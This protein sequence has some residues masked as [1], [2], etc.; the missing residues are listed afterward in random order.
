MPS[1]SFFSGDV[2]VVLKDKIFYPSK[3]FRR[4]TEITRLVRD[5]YSPDGVVADKPIMI[6]YTDGGPGH[7]ITYGSVHQ[8]PVI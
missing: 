3:A 2:H 8:W 6:Q 5:K 7:R 4:G 1:D